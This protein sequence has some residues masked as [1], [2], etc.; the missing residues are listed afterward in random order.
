M[1]FSTFFKLSLELP[2]TDEA[3]ATLADKPKKTKRIIIN[4]FNDPASSAAHLL[5]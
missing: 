3:N 4:D 1:Q 5:I 2:F